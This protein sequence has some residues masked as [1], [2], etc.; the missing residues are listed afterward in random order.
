M[1]PEIFSIGSIT[2]H[3]YGLMIA[4]AVLVVA[5]LLFREAPKEDL[6]P[7]FVIEAVIAATLAGLLGARIMYMALNWERYAAR[8]FA[9][10]FTQFEGLSFYGGFF[11]GVL[12]LLLWS[13]WRRIGFLRL[14]D[15]LAP[16]L[17]FGYAFGRIGCFL[18]GCCYGKESDLPWALPASMADEV[19]RHPVQ[20][21]AAFGALLIFVILKLLRPRRPFTGFILIMLFVLYGTLRFSTEFF[22]HGTAVWMGLT[23]AQ[24]FS[25]GLVILALAVLAAAFILQPDQKK[26]KKDR[27]GSKKS[28]KKKKGKKSAR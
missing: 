27:A 25:L 2:V 21:Y 5:V 7:D 10:F 23:D 17:A 16:Y 19:L 18:N 14:A 26:Q 9:A 11:G 4:L 28:G 22:R 24:L 1:F 6:N 13:R 12:I 20:L 15:L 8:P 3:A